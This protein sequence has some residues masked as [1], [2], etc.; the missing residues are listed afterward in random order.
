VQPVKRLLSLLVMLVVL[1]LAALLGVY[2]F[3]QFVWPLQ[4]ASSDKTTAEILRIEDLQFFVTHRVMTQ[5]TDE[6]AEYSVFT[7]EREGVL[8][9]TVKIYYGIDL[10]KV[11]QKPVMSES[12]VAVIELPEPEILD[13][14]TVPGSFRFFSRRTGLLALS[15]FVSG[16]NV[17]AELRDRFTTHARNFCTQ[18]GFLP[19]REDI[20]KSLSKVGEVLSAR[21]GTKIEFRYRGERK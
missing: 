4:S 17:E 18:N 21:S 2:G 10:K 7:G 14:S 19:S 8:I 11:D 15:D 1:G 13:I 3:R 9:G 16:R 20:L 5:V 12:G 6:I